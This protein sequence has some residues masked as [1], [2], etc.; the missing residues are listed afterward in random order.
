LFSQPNSIRGTSN[1]GNVAI[2]LVKSGFEIVAKVCLTAGV[3]EFEAKLVNVCGG[4]LAGF[5]SL[6][7][8]MEDEANIE[9][10]VLGQREEQVRVPAWVSYS[11][12]GPT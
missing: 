3:Y 11:R 8:S 6:P 9:R 7:V 10:G 5:I 4:L 1:L 2:V 12:L